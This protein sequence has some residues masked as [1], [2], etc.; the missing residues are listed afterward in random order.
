MALNVVLHLLVPEE[1][2]NTPAF[3]MFP[4]IVRE[5][6]AAVVAVV[7]VPAERMVKFV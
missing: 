5:C 2:L 3:A 6:V 4:P 7:K 1:K